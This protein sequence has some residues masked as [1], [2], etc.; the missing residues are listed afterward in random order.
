M[1]TQEGLLNYNI[2]VHNRFSLL[3]EEDLCSTAD[4]ESQ[5]QTLKETIT[6]AAK[7]TLAKRIAPKK[8][9]ISQETMD[10]LDKKRLVERNSPTYR[11]LFSLGKK[12]VRRDRKAV[13]HETCEVMNGV[14]RQLQKLISKI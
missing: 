7:L 5:W 10:I 12:A 13:I 11:A 8:P 2:E 3:A 1:F 6:V 14:F 4:S 9:W